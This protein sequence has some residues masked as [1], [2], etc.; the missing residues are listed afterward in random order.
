M[1]HFISKISQVLYHISHYTFHTAYLACHILPIKYQVSNDSLV[2]GWTG[3]LFLSQY[4]S[5][6]LWMGPA[7][8]QALITTFIKV[9]MFL[10]VGHIQ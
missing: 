1:S 7:S 10:Q 5:K 6:L 3:I 4:C 8:Y 9:T 2:Q